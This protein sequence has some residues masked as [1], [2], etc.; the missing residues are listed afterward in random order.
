MVYI[1]GYLPAVVVLPALVVLPASVLPALV[2]LPA[3][4]VLP[5]VRLP[6]L[7]V[8]FKVTWYIYGSFEH[9][10]YLW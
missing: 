9:M 6:V 3:V 2:V 4:V 7:W 1:S 8:V 5:V 10:V